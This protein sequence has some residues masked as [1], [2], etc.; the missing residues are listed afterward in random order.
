M[1]ALHRAAQRGYEVEVLL[2]LE[3]DADI[4]AKDMDGQTALYG[5]HFDKEWP[6]F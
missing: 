6:R 2:L 1:T 4:D 3:K 5:D